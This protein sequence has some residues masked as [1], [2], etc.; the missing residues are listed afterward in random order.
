MYARRVL[1]SLTYWAALTMMLL[2]GE[3]PVLVASLVSGGMVSVATW[4]DWRRPPK[5]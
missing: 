3:L 5:K 2:V 4:L 1:T